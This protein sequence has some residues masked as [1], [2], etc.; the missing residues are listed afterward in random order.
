MSYQFPEAEPYRIKVVEPLKLTDRDYRQG[1]LVKARYNVFNIPAEDVFVDLLTD[2]GTGA[3]SQDQWAGMMLGDESYAGA[4][5]WY[6]M[7]QT[8]REITGMPYVLPT[9]QGRPAE[10]ILFSILL[11]PGQL[12]LGNM[13]FDTTEAHVLSK[14]GQPENLVISAGLD[15]SVDY[16]FKGNIDI[17]RLEEVIQRAGPERVGLIMATVTCN[18]NGGQP[19]SIANLRAIRKI[20]DRFELPFYLD[21]ARFAENAFFIKLRESGYIDKSLRRIA[22]E[23]FSFVDGCTMSS[24]KDGL[25]NIGGFLATRDEAVFRKA[26]QY[27]VLLEGFLTYGGLAGRDLEAISRGLNE[28]L[29]EE[30][31]ANR[32]R[33]VRLLG[34]TMWEAGLPVFKPIGG[35]CVLLDMK[36]FLPHLPQD[37]FPAEAFTAQLYLDSGTRAVGLGQLAFGSRDPETGETRYAPLEVVRMAVP[38]RLYTDNHILVAARS[39]IR[40]HER[41]DAIPGMRL[42]WAPGALR[43]FTAHLEPIS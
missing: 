16:P 20:A 29:Q 7:Q 37:Q 36:S 11:Q 22:E 15:P 42:V 6:H 8:V 38:R 1:A 23:M 34:D 39:A 13:F 10:N 14:G 5:N 32:I 25:V 12:A 18:S 35:H 26:Q 31:M 43:H 24:K 28:V 19:V 17:E 27:L 3:M 2:S 21:A 30:Y 40:I 4:R 41:R 33:Q 9:H